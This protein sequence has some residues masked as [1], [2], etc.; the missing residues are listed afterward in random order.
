[1]LLASDKPFISFLEKRNEAKKFKRWYKNP[2]STLGLATQGY[3]PIT[4][5]LLTNL[6]KIDKRI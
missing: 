1:V 5:M 3:N 4:A 6:K 2:I